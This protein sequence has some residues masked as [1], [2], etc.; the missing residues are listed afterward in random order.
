MPI[1]EKEIIHDI[2]DDEKE[3]GINPILQPVFPREYQGKQVIINADRLIFNAKKQQ[4]V[5]GQEYEGG[6][7]HLFSYN[8]LGFS[9]EGSIHFNT[10]DNKDKSYFIVN[11]PNIFLGLDNAKEYP[12]EPAVLGNEN[13]IF[14]DKLLD[15]LK[16]TLDILS[17]RYRHIGDRGGYTTADGEV[18]KDMRQDFKGD[19]E[20]TPDSIGDLRNE[21]RKI[22]SQHVFLKK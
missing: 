5:D 19:G 3:K 15:F 18:F 1:E 8:F 6:D 11:S 7:I 20:I 14:M 10:S 12:T 2:W 4:K 16:T 21:L 13:Q 22:K 17:T 9:T